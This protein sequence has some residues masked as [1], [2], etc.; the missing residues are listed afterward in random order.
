MPRGKKRDNFSLILQILKSNHFTFIL[1]LSFSSIF[2]FVP[3]FLDLFDS[4]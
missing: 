3:I 2:L 4:W 1:N